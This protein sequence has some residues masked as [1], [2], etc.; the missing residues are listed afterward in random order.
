MRRSY[1]LSWPHASL[2]IAAN[3]TGS[4]E[5]IIDRTLAGHRR[6]TVRVGPRAK[7][8]QR[9]L[10]ACRRGACRRGLLPLRHR[11]FSLKFEGF[12][13]DAANSL[14]LPARRRFLRL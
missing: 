9:P 6:S 10:G 3:I 4:L 14:F 12:A 5:M 1:D 11:I 2:S 8:L 7:A 13:D